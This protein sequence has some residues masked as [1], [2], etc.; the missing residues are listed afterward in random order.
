MGV[1]VNG[2]FATPQKRHF[3]GVGFF[4]GF[5]DSAVFMH[6]LLIRQRLALGSAHPPT[7]YLAADSGKRLLAPNPFPPNRSAAVAAKKICSCSK[8]VL[9]LQQKSAA[10]A[11]KQKS[12]S[13]SK[14]VLQLHGA[15]APKMCCSCRF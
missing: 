8:K 11:A 1:F 12:C 3:L 14:H 9:Q 4:F 15:G 2:G 13:C 6:E 10:A 5:S 7:P